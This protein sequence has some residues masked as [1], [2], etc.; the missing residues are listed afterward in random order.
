MQKIQ[1]FYNDEN[2]IGQ[3]LNFMGE[4]NLWFEFSKDCCMLV[5]FNFINEEHIYASLKS[6]CVKHG[7]ENR[8]KGRD[9]DDAFYVFN[10]PAESAENCYQEL[11]RQSVP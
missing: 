2:V 8:I 7:S 9:C 1:T 10:I 5:C 6:L 4:A 3:N 11:K